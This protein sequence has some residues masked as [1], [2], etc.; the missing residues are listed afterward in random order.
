MDP[1]LYINGVVLNKYCEP[2][3]VIE[4]EERMGLILLAPDCET[5]RPFAFVVPLA[6]LIGTILGMLDVSDASSQSCGLDIFAGVKFTEQGSPFVNQMVYNF[7]LFRR[8]ELASKI[9]FLQY[10][11]QSHLQFHQ[12]LHHLEVVKVAPEAQ[13][14]Q[15]FLYCMADWSHL[16]L[17]SNS[18]R[19]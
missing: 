1:L 4:S 5:L 6:Y 10:L 15:G 11:H 7:C 8:S 18:L 2:L 12:H 9:G 14:E 19:L 13:T 3:N 17:G 16:Q